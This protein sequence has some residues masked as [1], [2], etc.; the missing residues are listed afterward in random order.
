MMISLGLQPCAGVHVQVRTGELEAHD[1]RA[2]VP[3]RHGLDAGEDFPLMAGQR[4]AHVQQIPETD[5]K[6]SHT[7]GLKT[8]EEFKK[9]EAL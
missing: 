1:R 5:R 4:H 6:S 9:Q 7:C 3:K 2:L 8:F